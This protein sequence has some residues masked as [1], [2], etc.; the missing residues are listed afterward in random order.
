[1]LLLFSSLDLSLF[2]LIFHLLWKNLLIN[3][4]DLQTS[5]FSKITFL[6]DNISHVSVF[7]KVMGAV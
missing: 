4:N 6:E 2:C 7:Y 5:E 1:M 3:K